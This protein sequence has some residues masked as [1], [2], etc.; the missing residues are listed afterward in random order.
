M[1]EGVSMDWEIFS[2]NTSDLFVIW[3]FYQQLTSNSAWK[4]PEI[5]IKSLLKLRLLLVYVRIWQ[6]YKPR[7]IFIGAFDG[8]IK[9]IRLD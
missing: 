3:L 9:H 2:S 6:F 1:I 8:T 7:P 5:K 4:A